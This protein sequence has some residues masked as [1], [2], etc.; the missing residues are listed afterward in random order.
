MGKKV[1]RYGEVNADILSNL[2]IKLNIENPRSIP[3]ITN[4]S[5]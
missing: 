1:D 2:T 4:A 3:A 5:Y